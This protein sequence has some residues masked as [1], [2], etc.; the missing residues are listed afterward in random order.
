MKKILFIIITL[1]LSQDYPD[2]GSD[3]SLDFVTWNIEW[4]PKNDEV[5]VEYVTEIIEQL[6]LD[7]LAIQELDDR[8]MFDQMLEALPDYTGYYESS[9]FA[10][11]A[12][13]YKTETI[14]IND[15]YEIYTTSPYWSAFPRSPMVMDINFM[16]ENYFFINN[17]F[18]CCGDGVLD[19][20]DESDEEKRRYNAINLLKEYIDDN[21]SYEKVIVL[22]DLNDDIAES[23]SNNVF[24]EILDDS[25]NYL[26]AD[27]E[28]ATG[29]ISNW[30]Y[31]NWPSH[32][33][34]ILITNELFNDLENGDIQTIKIDQY[35]NGGWSEYDYNI[36]DHRP[37]FMRLIPDSLLGDVNNDDLINILDVVIIVQMIIGDDVPSNNGD[38]NEDGTIN[39]LDIVLL[40]EYIIDNWYWALDIWLNLLSVLE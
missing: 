18:K 38:F 29:S 13:I 1:V 36:S 37:V 32:L 24:Q 23:Y 35:L 2:L 5:T 14:E 19:F 31:P 20:N 28:I 7:I 9:W 11:L 25:N 39:I 3:N 26:F 40:I 8:D 34:H 15:I 4:F 30:S 21:L 10:G 33:D 6:D 27:M 12:Y 17:H 22:G 16:G